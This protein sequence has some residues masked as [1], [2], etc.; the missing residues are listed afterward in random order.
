M[1]WRWVNVMVMPRDLLKV[2]QKAR[3][4]GFRWVMRW[5]MHSEK[6]T[7]LPMVTPKAKNRQS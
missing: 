5:V 1:D 7:D 6:M 4:L 3:R 2:N